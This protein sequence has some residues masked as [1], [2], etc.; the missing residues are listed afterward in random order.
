MSARIFPAV[1][2]FLVTWFRTITAL[3]GV[4][5]LLSQSVGSPF[6]A[7]AAAFDHDGHHH[8]MHV[9]NVGGMM[10]VAL[11]HGHEAGELDDDHDHEEAPSGVPADSA[12][13]AHPH[14]HGDHVLTVGAGQTV[15]WGQPLVTFKS[16]PCAALRDALHIARRMAYPRT[17]SISQCAARPPPGRPA[18]LGCLRTTVLIV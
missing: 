15:A 10:V 5:G 9:S 16:M 7:D 12:C 4:A 13:S 6:L 11:S 18:L 8:E 2:A 17:L 3:C 14:P 1:P